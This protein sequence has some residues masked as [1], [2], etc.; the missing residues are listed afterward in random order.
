MNPC[1]LIECPSDSKVKSNEIK[2]E[3]EPNEMRL[4]IKKTATKLK[5]A[6]KAGDKE[7]ELLSPEEEAIIEPEQLSIAIRS[8]VKR[9]EDEAE[10]AKSGLDHPRVVFW[11]SPI[12][13]HHV[14]LT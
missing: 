8:A 9:R 5:K 2:R 12:L 10:P 4:A 13:L 1:P 14:K 7:R 6:L 3:L 11:F